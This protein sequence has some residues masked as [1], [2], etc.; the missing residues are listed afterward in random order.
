MN[1]PDVKL[2]TNELPKSTCPACCM[3]FGAATGEA[4]AKPYPGAI[5]ICV[6]C[7]LVGKYDTQLRVVKLTD[8]EYAELKTNPEA[9]NQIQNYIR[10]LKMTGNP[11]KRKR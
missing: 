5:T 4:G 6:N 1:P 9:W 8:E 11:Y 2:E 7:Y 10:V 3:V